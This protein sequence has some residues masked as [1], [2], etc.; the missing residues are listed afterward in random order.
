MTFTREITAL[1]TSFL[2]WASLLAQVAPRLFAAWVVT[3]SPHAV[4][5]RDRDAGFTVVKHAQT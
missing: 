4:P 1:Q 2:R 3:L 5:S